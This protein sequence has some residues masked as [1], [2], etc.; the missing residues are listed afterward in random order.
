MTAA[1]VTTT[2]VQ[3]RALPVATLWRIV[4][5]KLLELVGVVVTVTLITTVLIRLAPGS[6]ASNILGDA[7]SQESIDR[8]N[9]QLGLNDPLL[10]QVGRNLGQ[11]FTGNL[12]SSIVQSRPVSSIVAQSLP[13]TLTL[14]LSAIVLAVVVGIPIGLAA[15]FSQKRGYDQAVGVGTSLL[16]A[17]PPFVVGTLLIYLL[18]VNFKVFPA[19]GWGTNPVT[20]V[21]HLVLPAVT[22]AILI[23]SPIIRS[24]FRST[25]D[26]TGQEYVDAARSRGVSSLRIAFRHVLP[27]VSVPLITL[28]CYSAAILIGGAI[29]VEV[30]FGLP[31]FGQAI[32]TAVLSRDYPTVAGMTLV[33]AVLVVL[34]T[35]VGDLLTLVADP[36]RR[37]VK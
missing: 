6:P 16:I 12:G 15:G 2:P 30:V 21:E 31:G 7:A 4:V 1:T 18:A 22:L 19:G 8:L 27:V 9:Q 20:I 37:L 10:V 28:L 13:I 5:R 11:L 32:N 34:I 33:V 3:R 35:T 25:R 24:V 26:A 29:I 36:R 14:I 23:V 17:L